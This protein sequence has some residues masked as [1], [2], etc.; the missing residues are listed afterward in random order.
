MSYIP[1]N[2]VS[3]I[4]AFLSGLDTIVIPDVYS[5]NYALAAAAGLDDP[6]DEEYSHVKILPGGEY[7]LIEVYTG[8]DFYLDCSDDFSDTCGTTDTAIS[9]ED[10]TDIFIKI[11]RDGT[12][13]HVFSWEDDL[14]ELNKY[15]CNRCETCTC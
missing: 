6:E 2:Y 14:A 10:I 4:R 9:T 7:R 13:Y 5:D 12:F 8:E 15:A 1:G 11:E 3:A